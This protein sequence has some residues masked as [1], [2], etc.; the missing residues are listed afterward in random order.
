MPLE[1]LNER[2]IA[3]AQN[4]KYF[5]KRDKNTN[6]S[7]DIY[8]Q[9]EWTRS[10]WKQEL[11]D[12]NEGCCSHL[13]GHVEYHSLFICIPH[14]EVR[15]YVIICPPT[16]H[17]L[18]LHSPYLPP[19]E[20]HSSHYSCFSSLTENVYYIYLF[21]SA[22]VWPRTITCT[23]CQFVIIRRVVRFIFLTLFFFVFISSIFSS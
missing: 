18:E 7:L 10:V 9:L 15:S 1:E 23:S 17:V 4:I 21:S 19:S 22:I 6:V 13:G 5:I 16:S 11:P 20:C 3:P 14:R 12:Q 8:I 2:R